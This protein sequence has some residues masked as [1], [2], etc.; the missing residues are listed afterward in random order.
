MLQLLFP[1]SLHNSYS[2]EAVA[3]TDPS[4]AVMTCWPTQLSPLLIAT[5][6]RTKPGSTQMY[7]SLRQ[8]QSDEF[9]AVEHYVPATSFHVTD[10]GPSG[11][12]GVPDHN[13]LE[14]EG[15]D[16]YT[17][18][19]P[20]NLILP[21]CGIV[22]GVC[23]LLDV[24]ARPTFHFGLRFQLICSLRLVEVS[25]TLKWSDQDIVCR[26]ANVVVE[27]SLEL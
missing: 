4:V 26:C 3:N 24:D 10:L 27:E 1:Y 21:T 5:N 15:L 19:W 13:V 11:L 9:S 22:Y 14:V 17:A 18:S 25:Y 8:A 7:F 12:L 6:P 20:N 23:E 2:V 16:L